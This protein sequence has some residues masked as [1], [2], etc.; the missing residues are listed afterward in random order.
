VLSRQPEPS[1]EQ[2]IYSLGSHTAGQPVE[3]K[4][5]PE[6]LLLTAITPMDDA[7]VGRLRSQVLARDLVFEKVDDQT[8]GDKKE[9][10]VYVVNPKGGP[11][12]RLVT[13]VTLTH[14]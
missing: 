6:R 4:E 14:R 8:P 11:E 1:L 12:S 13:D 3:A 10:A 2:L 5:P 7:L 9:K